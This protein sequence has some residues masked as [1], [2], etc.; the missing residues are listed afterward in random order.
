MNCITK[1]DIKKLDVFDQNPEAGAMLKNT[2]KGIST[3]AKIPEVD[4]I[5]DEDKKKSG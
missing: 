1:N 5:H 2:R 3:N 4:P